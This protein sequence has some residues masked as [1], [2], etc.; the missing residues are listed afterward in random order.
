VE[1]GMRIDSWRWK[2]GLIHLTWLDVLRIWRF[3]RTVKCH[4]LGGYIRI[5]TIYIGKERGTTKDGS[6]PESVPELTPDNA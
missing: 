6:Q 5:W 4:V 1:N 2:N 3:V